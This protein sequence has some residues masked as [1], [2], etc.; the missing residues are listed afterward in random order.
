MNSLVWVGIILILSGLLRIILP[1]IHKSYKSAFLNLLGMKRLADWLRGS[2]N[3]W[4]QC[5]AHGCCLNETPWTCSILFLFNRLCS[6]RCWNCC[7]FSVKTALTILYQIFHFE[8]LEG[9]VERDRLFN[10]TLN[11][12]MPM[13]WKSKNICKPWQPNVTRPLYPSCDKMKFNIIQCFH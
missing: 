10:Q 7:N 4:V 12:F 8:I 13:W 1:G 5:S 2:T 11:E 6:C 3:A 9:I